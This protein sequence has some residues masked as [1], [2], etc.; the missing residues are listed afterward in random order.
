VSLEESLS[1][2]AGVIPHV[3]EAFE[4]RFPAL[5][6]RAQ[7]RRAEDITADLVYR[8]GQVGT[9][10]IAHHGRD[11]VSRWMAPA[12]TRRPRPPVAPTTNSEVQPPST[13][14]TAAA[15]AAT[16]RAG[17]P[18]DRADLVTGKPQRATALRLAGVPRVCAV[19]HEHHPFS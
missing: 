3:R 16:A 19:T 5:H 6:R 7:A 18:E 14:A 1:F 4:V 8:I 11:V 10:R 9:G 15:S 12:T 13:A 17:R 2:L